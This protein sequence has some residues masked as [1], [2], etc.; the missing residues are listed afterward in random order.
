MIG[1]MLIGR[2]ALDRAVLVDLGA[3]ARRQDE[4]RLGELE[5]DRARRGR[6]AAGLAA[7]DRGLDPLVAEA[8]PARALL[9]A[10]ARRWPPR[11][12]A[13]GRR[14][15]RPGGCRRARPRRRDRGGRSGRSWA[16]AKRATRSAGSGSGSRGT[17]SS[18]AWPRVAHARR[19]PRRR[20]RS[21]PVPAAC[22][23]S[24]TAAA[25]RSAVSSSP[26]SITVRAVSRRRSDAQRPKAER[27]P[28]ARG[29]RRRS[30]PSSSAIAA[31]C[32]GPAPPKGR[33]A[34]WRG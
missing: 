28:P 20:A 32:I 7:E 5:D 34:K 29:Q 6:P 1:S 30:M 33:R 12:R 24:V 9:D 23:I 17:G 13:R 19:R 3:P 4:G 18:N 8:G 10:A 26:L 27:T 25:I 21:S 15:P 31:A 22:R 2:A 16:S 14:S 11:A